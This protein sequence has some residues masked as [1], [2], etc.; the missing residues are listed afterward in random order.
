MSLFDTALVMKNPKVSI[1]NIKK[2]SFDQLVGQNREMAQLAPIP[3]TMKD[4]FTS[5]N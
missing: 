1:Q 5:Y 3:N 2:I 4:Y